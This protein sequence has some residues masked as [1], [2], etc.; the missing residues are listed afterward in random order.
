MRT[1]LPSKFLKSTAIGAALSI[2]CLTP[3]YSYA[4]ESDGITAP[5]PITVAVTKVKDRSG[6]PWWRPSFEEALKE[7]L[8]TE[9]SSAGH[10]IVL[11]RD[12]EALEDIQKEQTMSWGWWPFGGEKGNKLNQAQYIIRAS[13]SDY[14]EV[15]D[16]G[17]QQSVG[18]GGFAVGGGKST[19]EF[20][21]SFDLKVI[22]TKTGTI[23]YS[24][25]IEG[26]AKN[27]TKSNAFS[28]NVR[29]FSFGESKQKSTRTPTKKAVRDAMIETASYLDCVLYLKDECIAEFKAKDAKRK[30]NSS[31]D[32]F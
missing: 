31:L 15:S 23:A 24:R 28:G 11:E 27:V 29:G 7:I 32:M 25:S 21:V 16:E 14:A 13:L 26:K 2:S 20:Y 30:S 22:N 6:A 8:S 4:N 3:Q 17:G 18:F 19:K 5:K 10:F 9:L 1:T 12:E